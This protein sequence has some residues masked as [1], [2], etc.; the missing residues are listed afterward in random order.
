MEHSGNGSGRWSRALGR[1]LDQDAALSVFL[2]LLV[3]STLLSWPLREFLP[4]QIFDVLAVVTILFGV[5]V[6]A[7]NPRVAV[8]GGIIGAAVAVQR[9]SGIGRLS[10]LETAPALAFFVVL[11][12]ALFVRVFRPGKIT[13]HR[14]LGAVA[15]FVVLAVTWGLAY[16]TV[17]ALRPR[18]FLT[19]GRPASAE[20]LMWF[21]IVTIST[22]GYGDVLPATS[23]ARALSALEALTGVLYPSVL[24]G[25]LVSQAA[26]SWPGRGRDDPGHP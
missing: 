14:L 24:I 18:A 1:L 19:G 4:H 21:S 13:V 15:L 23:L 7:P 6:L 8:V 11:A 10:A 2:V 16:Q 22:V 17:Q 5:A 3:S 9:V 26:A 25:F 20:D 12:A